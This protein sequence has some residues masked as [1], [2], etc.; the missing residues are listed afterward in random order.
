[1]AGDSDSQRQFV[2]A[3]CLALDS[4]SVRHSDK[5]TLSCTRL[6]QAN[7]VIFDIHSTTAFTKSDRSIY[8]L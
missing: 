4:W 3:M 2:R 1:M 6:D 8:W 5:I 7:S